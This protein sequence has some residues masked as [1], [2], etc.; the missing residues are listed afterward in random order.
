MHTY[1]TVKH[2]KVST[3]N[4]TRRG[5]GGLLDVKEGPSGVNT[6]PEVLS[7]ERKY[8]AYNL[9]ADTSGRKAGRRALVMAV[10]AVIG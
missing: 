10:V 6:R 9:L 1:Q 5:H 8:S 2:G 4:R 7:R 3:P